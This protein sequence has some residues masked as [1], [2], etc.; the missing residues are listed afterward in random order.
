MVAQDSRIEKRFLA[1]EVMVEARC[2]IHPWMVAHIGVV[3]HPW[4]AVTGTDGRFAIAGVP[5]GRYTLATWH[6]SLG[7]RRREVVVVSGSIVDA[8]FAFGP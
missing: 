3:A 6:E 7:V 2:D 1:P 4:F 8:G 5:E